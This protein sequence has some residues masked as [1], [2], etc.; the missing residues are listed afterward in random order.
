[1]DKIKYKFAIN[2]NYFLLVIIP[3]LIMFYPADGNCNQKVKVIVKT[4]YA[5]KNKKSVDPRIKNLVK[6]LNSA[7]VYSS[8]ELLNQK[9]LT[10]SKGENTVF[11]IHG[12][13]KVSITSKGINGGK[14]T[15]EIKCNKGNRELIKTNINFRNNGDTT[16]ALPEGKGDKLFLHILTSF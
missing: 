6:D 4:I 1:M 13:K 3:L 2:W 5:S 10:L 7:F 9:N 12:G 8:Y 16:I 11:G 14:A 15:L